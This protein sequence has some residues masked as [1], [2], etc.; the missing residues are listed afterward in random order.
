M[1]STRDPAGASHTLAD[2]DKVKVKGSSSTYTLSRTGNVYMC[3]C[4]AGGGRCGA[5]SSSTA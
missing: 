4:P 5:A 2:G 1:T 3:S